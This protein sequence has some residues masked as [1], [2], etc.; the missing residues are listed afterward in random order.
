MG[1]SWFFSCSTCRMKALSF[2]FIPVLGLLVC[3][4]S[5]CPVDKAIS[6]KIQHVTSSLGENPPTEPQPGP[7]GPL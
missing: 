7:Q 6:E 3:G 2:L 1:V 4:Q 5:L